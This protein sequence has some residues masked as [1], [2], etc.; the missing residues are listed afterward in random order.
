MSDKEKEF[1]FTAQIEANK[2]KQERLAKERL[3]ANNKL[4]PGLKNRKR[5]T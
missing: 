5:K 2:K 3:E 4:T 1:D